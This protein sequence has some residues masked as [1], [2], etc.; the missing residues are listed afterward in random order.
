[1]TMLNA[2]L[3]ETTTTTEIQRRAD[4]LLARIARLVNGWIATAIARRER[5]AALH[6]L[7]QFSDREL[8]DTGLNRSDLGADLT[9][10]SRFRFRGQHPRRS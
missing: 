3:S 10:P 8:K 5:Q 4:I 7:R 9:E 2:A 6:V 1:M